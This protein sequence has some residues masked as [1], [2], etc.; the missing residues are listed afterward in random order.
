[1]SR[2]AAAP[3]AEM[4]AELSAIGGSRALRG[5]GVVRGQSHE[6][7]RHERTSCAEAERRKAPRQV[8]TAS[9]LPARE[10]G[11]G[12]EGRHHHAGA[13]GRAFRSHGHEGRSRL[14][15]SLAHRNG[16]R[17]KK[18]SA[19]ERARSSR[20]QAGARGMRGR[21]L[22]GLRLRAKAPFG[23]W[24]TQTLSPPALPWAHR[25]VRGRYR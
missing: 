20:R 22:K 4:G 18:N 5:V 23:H 10:A 1:M 19:G 9:G 14:A 8:R 3:A 2:P 21:C 11:T 12:R 16:Y 6:N 25:A 17:F 24:K 13:F 7:L 15:V